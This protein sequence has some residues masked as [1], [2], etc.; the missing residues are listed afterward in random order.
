MLCSVNAEVFNVSATCDS[1]RRGT[2]FLNHGCVETP[3]FMPCGTYGSVKGMTPLQLAEVGTQIL[4]GNTFHLMLR[5]G[6]E[7]IARLGGLHRFMFWSKPILTDSGGFQ[8]F[9]LETLRRT[10]DD[11]V[12]FRSPINGDRVRL[13][14][15]IS[16]SVQTNLGADIVMVFDECTPQPASMKVTHDSMTRSMVW[17]KRSKNFYGGNGSLFGIVQGGLYDDL[18]LENLDR[19][20]TI[21][22]DGYAIGGLS[23]GETTD[24][25]FGVLNAL[26]P[27]M[28]ENRPRYL[29]GV[30]TPSDLI[31]GVLLGVDMFDC[32]LPT[33]NA[34][35]GHV[36]SWNGI[37]RIRNAKFRYDPEPLSPNCACYACRHFSRAYIHHLD[38]CHE[39]L[40]ATLMTIHNL[41]FYHELMSRIRACIEKGDLISA[42][43][44]WLSRWGQEKNNEDSTS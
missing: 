23:V 11:G 37:V 16:M 1:A 10:D 13:T 38:K 39:M 35:N 17:A 34:R 7:L 36:F 3:V 6:D 2:L 14:P 22:F 41:H 19:L 15:E 8:V 33:R 28:P 26:L 27:Q 20:T 25:M 9:S 32:V 5:P 40:G 21:G 4:L 31:K 30:G 24:E 29:M 44:S 12:T 43:R 42:S 18:R